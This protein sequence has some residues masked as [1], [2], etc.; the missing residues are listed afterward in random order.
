MI[1]L[2]FAWGLSSRILIIFHTLRSVF[3]QT[4]II[5]SSNCSPDSFILIRQ[6]FCLPFRYSSWPFPL[7]I[8]YIQLIKV[9]I[10]LFSRPC[11]QK[12]YRFCCYIRFLSWRWGWRESNF[13]F[14]I[15]WIFRWWFP[16][17]S[18]ISLRSLR[19]LHFLIC[20]HYIFTLRT[21]KDQPIVPMLKCRY[22]NI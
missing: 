2:W 17:Q 7:F 22:M 3:Q 18:I 12:E 9:F 15:N 10:C 16:F 21:S 5:L 20:T 6:L 8:I 14:E 4:S 1:L 11:M 19:N 13:Q